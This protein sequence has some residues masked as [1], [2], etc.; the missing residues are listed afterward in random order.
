M[1]LVQAIRDRVLQKCFHFEILICG[2]QLP[3]FTPLPQSS[4]RE[5]VQQSFVGASNRQQS[6][7]NVFDPKPDTK[8]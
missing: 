4:K 6:R 5:G 3:P 8:R 7:N 2:S 1:W